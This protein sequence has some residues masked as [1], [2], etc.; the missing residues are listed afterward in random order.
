MSLKNI[1]IV[2]DT[3]TGAEQRLD[4]A[5]QI[6]QAHDAHVTGLCVRTTPHVPQFV[7][8]QLGPE[9]AEAQRQWA[10]E[11]AEA[12]RALFD[13]K[14]AAAGVRGEWQVVDGQ[15]LEQVALHAKY[16]D[17]VVLGQFNPD[18][19]MADGQDHLVDHVVMDAGR[20]VLVVPYCGT[21]AT[22]GKRV[23]MA[24]NA[25][26]EATRAVNDALPLLQKADLVNVVA[27]NPHGGT[28]RNGHGEIPSSDICLH[29][30]RHGVKADAQTIEAHDMDVG[31]A[32]LSRI[33]DEGVDL[34]VMGAY[35]RSR[36]RELVL[37]GATRHIL[38]HMTVPVLMSH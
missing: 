29:L 38:R 25:T 10:T 33:T 11:A 23:M 32:L 18:A 17:L 26:R 19:D 3:A 22:V 2:M 6:A 12:A 15:L 20:P 4:V 13:S 16:S 37:G 30:A 27:V 14:V 31:D 21:F 5:L 9:V 7:M 24:W 35:G 1:M 34:L 28:G 8:S 36:L